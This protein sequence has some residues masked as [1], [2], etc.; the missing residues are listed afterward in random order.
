G[1]RIRPTL[2]SEMQKR[3][4]QTGLATLCIGG[5]RGGAT[6]VERD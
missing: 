5:G 2:L 1:G 4:A 6:N 3:D